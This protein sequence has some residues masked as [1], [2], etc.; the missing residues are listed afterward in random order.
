MELLSYMKDASFIVR[1][2]SQESVMKGGRGEFGL[3]AIFGDSYRIQKTE[4]SGGWG[5]FRLLKDAISLEV[6]ND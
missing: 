3:I 6:A 4:P 1:V 2:V 5:S